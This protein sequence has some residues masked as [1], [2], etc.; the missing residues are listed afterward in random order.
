MKFL[1]IIIHAAV[2]II[3]NNL[4]NI[5]SIS[6]GS[7][8]LLFLFVAARFL[9]LTWE[10]YSHH[11][12]LHLS[13]HMFQFQIHANLAII[14]SDVKIVTLSVNGQDECMSIL[15]IG[16]YLKLTETRVEDVYR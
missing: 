1:S 3:I 15:N 5:L 12:V 11:F 6:S 7:A 4:K 16:M 8:L 9:K 2:M 14:L 13:I 10:S